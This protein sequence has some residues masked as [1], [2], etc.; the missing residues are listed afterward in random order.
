LDN[1]DR[2]TW[3]ALKIRQDEKGQRRPLI[4]VYDEAHNLTDQQVDLLLELEPEAF[5]LASATMRLSQ[6]LSEQIE[7]PFRWWVA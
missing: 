6:H 3:E 7:Y 5:L 2:S 1:A 4:V